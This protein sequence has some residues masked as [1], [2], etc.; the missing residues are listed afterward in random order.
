[1][2]WVIESLRD[3]AFVQFE[4]VSSHCIKIDQYTL[5]AASAAVRLASIVLS[6]NVC[7][8]RN[9]WPETKSRS[10]EYILTGNDCI[11]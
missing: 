2:E 1:M 10:R 11:E 5:A 8:C 3:D 7:P 6:P 4:K 9:F